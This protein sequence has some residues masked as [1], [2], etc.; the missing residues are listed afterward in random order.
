MMGFGAD[1]THFVTVPSRRVDNLR[2]LEYR[3]PDGARLAVARQTSGLGGRMATLFGMDQDADL[4]YELRDPSGSVHLRARTRYGRGSSSDTLVERPVGTAFGSLVVA[5]EGGLVLQLPDG[6]RAGRLRK[7]ADLKGGAE[8]FH[9]IDATGMVVA[10]AVAGH[11]AGRRRGPTI[12]YSHAGRGCP[13]VRSNRDGRQLADEV[14]ELPAVVPLWRPA[15]VPTAE[16]RTETAQSCLEGP[17]HPGGHGQQLL[18][19][20]PAGGGP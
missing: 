16:L 1:L 2:R 12:A 9:V 6:G 17:R 7:V 19:L 3:S 14:L 10:T 13:P 11:R 15:H 8:G 18:G 4:D 5:A 20:D